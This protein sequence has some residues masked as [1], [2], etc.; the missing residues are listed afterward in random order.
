MVENY[1]SRISQPIL[2]RIDIFVNVERVEYNDLCK[3]GDGE[4][5]ALVR[6]RVEK[7]RR[8]QAERYRGLGISINSELT[9]S[10]IDEF[11]PLGVEERKFMQRAFDRF[12]LSARGYHRTL[13]VAR[14]ISDME[15]SKDIILPH[16]SEALSYRGNSSVGADILK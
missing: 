12:S 3:K 1:R 7:T 16:L 4:C 8:V 5:S 13:K 2:D 9:G 15:G 10:M 11:C 14:T 6:A